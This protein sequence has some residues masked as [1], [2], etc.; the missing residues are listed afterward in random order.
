MKWWQ[1]P[2]I[3]QEVRGSGSSWKVRTL[4]RQKSSVLNPFLMWKESPSRLQRPFG[5]DSPPHNPGG[6]SE[7][8]E[9]RGISTEN[10]KAEVELSIHWNFFEGIFP[11][12]W[13]KKTSVLLIMFWILSGQKVPEPGLGWNRGSHEATGCG[14][15]S[16]RTY[17]PRAPLASWLGSSLS[18]SSCLSTQ[19]RVSKCKRMLPPLT[20]SRRPALAFQ[21]AELANKLQ[22]P[23]QIWNLDKQ[24]FF[25][26]YR[27]IPVL[28]K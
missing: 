16:L 26:L 5:T 19:A 13:E 25:L 14:L 17:P 15:G 8:I 27:H 12:C 23:S 7:S 10:W 24:P 9:N 21:S 11:F 2:E 20:R 28:L 3:S 22:D 4:W 18:G 6:I 1:A